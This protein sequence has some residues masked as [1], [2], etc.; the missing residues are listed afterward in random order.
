LLLDHAFPS[1]PVQCAFLAD[2]VYTQTSAT[3]NATVPPIQWPVLYSTTHV[4]A[5]ASEVG[6]M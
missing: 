5:Q 3:A 2:S 1:A 6:I 4:I